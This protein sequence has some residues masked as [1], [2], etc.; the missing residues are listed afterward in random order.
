[1]FLI[2][3]SAAESTTANDAAATATATECLG[4][5]KQGDRSIVSS[6]AAT[7]SP[8]GPKQREECY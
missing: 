3:V 8:S 5:E 4:R 6:T 2:Q 1:L 7:N